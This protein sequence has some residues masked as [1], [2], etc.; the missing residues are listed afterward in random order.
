VC[1]E[2]GRVLRDCRFK[3]L[4]ISVFNFIEMWCRDGTWR[5]G[6]RKVCTQRCVCGGVGGVGGEG[7]EGV[8]RAKWGSREGMRES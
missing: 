6:T 7:S 4:C 5:L 3:V 2:G 8:L 1:G